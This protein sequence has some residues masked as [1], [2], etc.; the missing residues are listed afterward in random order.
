MKTP[1]DDFTSHTAQGEVEI[2]VG[3]GDDKMEYDYNEEILTEKTYTQVL[4]TQIKSNFLSIST[5]V[6]HTISCKLTNTI[7]NVYMKMP[8]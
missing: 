8:M 5:Y 4:Q 3:F 7:A 6:A 2:E 1:E